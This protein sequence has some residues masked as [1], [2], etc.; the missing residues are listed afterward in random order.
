[1]YIS[2]SV[3]YYSFTIQGYKFLKCLRLVFGAPA[4]CNSALDYTRLPK[5]LYGAGST[6]GGEVI[7]RQVS[8]ETRWVVMMIWSCESLLIMMEE[9]PKTRWVLK[10]DRFK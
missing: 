7:I 5:L 9:S 4:R 8:L 3:W 6:S 10:M 1:M 2:F